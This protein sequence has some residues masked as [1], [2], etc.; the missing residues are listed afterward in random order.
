M[1]IFTRIFLSFWLMIVALIGMTIVLALTT[2]SLMQ[3]NHLRVLPIFPLHTCAVATLDEYERGGRDALVRYLGTSRTS[4]SGGVVVHAR[5]NR[6]FSDLGPKL[7]S[8]EAATGQSTPETA[9]VT[10]RELPLHTV[11][12]LPGPLGRDAPGFFL[13][14]QRPYVFFVNSPRSLHALLFFLLSRIALLIVV[15]SVCCYLLTSYL[16]KP[17]IRLGRMA[18]QLGGG[19]LAIRIEGTLLARK[20]ELGEFSRKFNQMASEI[21]SLVT[22]YKHFLAHASHE[23]GSPLTRVNIA[24]GLARKKADPALQPE[25]NRIGHETKRL[26]TLVQEL[27]FLARLESGNELSW[28]TTSFDAALMIE[29]ACAD[30]SFEAAQVGKSVV[31]QKSETLQVTGHRELLRRALDNI[32]RN[33]LR[34]AREAGAV[35][36]DVSHSADKRVGII[37]VQDDGP[38]IAPEQEEMIFEPFVTLPNGATGANGGSGLGLAIARQAVIVN[39]GKVYA[40]SSESGGLTVTIELPTSVLQID[41]VSYSRE[42]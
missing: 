20:D 24:L 39:G 28:Q 31:L 10:V 32:L 42:V 27:L 37:T 6:Q 2:V 33:G 19:D 7:A 12:A 4:C 3:P 9:S 35:R 36:V 11:V 40:R 13:L 14:L 5:E 18:E 16:V 29:E 1:K 30:A 26:N 41:T 38:G 34:F 22:R 8:V 17:V 21:E 25:L 23:L 15:S